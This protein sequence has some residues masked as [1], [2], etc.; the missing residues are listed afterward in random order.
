M[1][2]INITTIHTV[3]WVVAQDLTILE[4]N[5]TV[6]LDFRISRGDR[7]VR[8]R[9]FAYT[10]GESATE[11]TNNIKIHASGEQ[12]LLCIAVQNLWD[13]FVYWPNSVAI[14]NCQTMLGF[15]L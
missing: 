2:W 6:N 3:A 7:S 9:A 11:G 12:L 5:T 10:G 13:H 1:L 4:A 15:R 14:L 8:T